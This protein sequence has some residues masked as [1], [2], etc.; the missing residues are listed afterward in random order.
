MKPLNILLNDDFEPQICDFGLAR[1]GGGT[2]M[3][4]V[5]LTPLTVA[6]EMIGAE[7][8]DTYTGKADV[9]SYGVTL[10]MMFT[11]PTAFDDGRRGR[12]I[13]WPS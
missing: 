4:L 9:Y 1:V 12:K 11:N 7:E 10:Y 6:P 8:G 3:S 5:P 2:G 13:L